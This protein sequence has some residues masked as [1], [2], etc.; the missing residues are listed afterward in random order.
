MFFKEINHYGDRGLIIDFGKESTREISQ[1]INLTFSFLKE[2]NLPVLNITPSFNKIVIYFKTPDNK[3]KSL[4]FLKSQFQKLQPSINPSKQKKWKIP[5]CY[6]APFALDIEK[7][8][9]LHSLSKQEVI[10]LHTNSIYYTYYIGF[11][12]GFPY[13]GEVHK[14]LVSPRLK[15]PRVQIPARS[16]GIAKQH[17]CIYPKVSPG[18]WNIIAQIPFDIFSLNHPRAS[19]FLPGDEVQFYAVTLKDFESI[20]KHKLSLQDL[21]KEY[22]K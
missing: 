22:S 8:Q 6:E 4:K 20:Q 1:E 16:V 14:S 19:L 11:M 17:T 10:D 15:S 21:I 13:L 9:K 7:I 3:D 5:A 18:G 2:L 12:P